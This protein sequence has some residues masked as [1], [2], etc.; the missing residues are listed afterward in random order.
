MQGE[1][2]REKDRR[3]KI[4]EKAKRTTRQY[5]LRTQMNASIELVEAVFAAQD[6]KCRIC[7]TDLK[8]ARWG[9]KVCDHDHLTG[10]FRSVLCCKCNA[11]LG[12]FNEDLDLLKNVMEYLTAFHDQLRA[13]SSHPR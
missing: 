2:V 12:Y 13:R 7:K 9:K 11:G 10:Q 6:Y 8:H 1:F 3:H 4:S 5:V